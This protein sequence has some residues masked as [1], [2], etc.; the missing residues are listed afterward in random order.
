MGILG[1]R[2]AQEPEAAAAPSGLTVIAVGV[3]VRGSIDSN[4]TIKVE[5]SVEGD[6]STR[7]Q[8]LVAKGGIIEGDV[9]AKEAIV[10]GTVTGAIRA[11]ER[12]EIQTG[13]VVEGDITTRRIL[14]A[15]GGSLNGQVR[16]G[17]A[18]ATDAEAL[19]QSLPA[20]SVSQPPGPVVQRSSVPFA[21]VAVPPGHPSP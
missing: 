11:Q 9:V 6:V 17:D 10:G 13:A 16:M 3:A 15:E 19:R 5:G 18:V 20:P 7:A 1:N 14:V 8:I 12:V 2:K 4:G 21:R